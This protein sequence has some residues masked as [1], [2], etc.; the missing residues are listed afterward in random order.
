MEWLAPHFPQ[1][2]LSFYNQNVED[3]EKECLQYENDVDRWC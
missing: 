2:I 3:V 1:P